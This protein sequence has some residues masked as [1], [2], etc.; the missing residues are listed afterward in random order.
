MSCMYIHIYMYILCISM[1]LTVYTY[2]INRL[3]MF[4]KYVI[5]GLLIFNNFSSNSLA[6]LE[7]LLSSCLFSFH[8]VDLVR[9]QSECSRNVD[10][11]QSEWKQNV[12]SQNV[13]RLL[14]GCS[15]NTIRMQIE[16]YQP[17]RHNERAT[18]NNY[19]ICKFQSKMVKHIFDM[20]IS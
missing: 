16:N 15:Q 4:Y 7:L 10:G 14:L 5:K 2:P 18:E 8:L 6:K 9:M 19:S 12:C 13:L 1:S 20:H 3:C 17:T 11:M